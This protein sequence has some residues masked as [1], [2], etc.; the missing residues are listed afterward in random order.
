MNL[1]S[2]V[3][4]ETSHTEKANT[5]GPHLYVESGLNTNSSNFRDAPNLSALSDLDFLKK[6]QIKRTISRLAEY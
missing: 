5:E 1:E 6:P 2:S 4:R 3:L